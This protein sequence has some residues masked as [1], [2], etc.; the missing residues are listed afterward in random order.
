MNMGLHISL[1]PEQLFQLGPF[2]V[3]NSLLT[4]WI[5]VVLLC[6]GAKKISKS[7]KMVPSYGMLAVEMLIE[8]IYNLTESVAGPRSK[9]FFPYIITLFIFILTSNWIGLMPGMGTILLETAHA[10][11]KVALFRAP[12]ADLNTTLALALLSVGLIQYFGLKLLGRTYLKKFFN[13]KN[14]IYTFVGFLE[15]IGEISKIISF[16][17]RLFG[18]IFAG[19]VLLVVIA[20]LVPV[21]APLPFYGLEIFVGFIQAFVFVMLSLVFMNMATLQT[22]H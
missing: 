18:N 21:V 4:S 5:V 6:L 14:P 15:I 16:A 2:P 13:L 7:I 8:G 19:E 3:S 20:F 10:E 9:V 17:F 22:E 11:E 1:A 12:T